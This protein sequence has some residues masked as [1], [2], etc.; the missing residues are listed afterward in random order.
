M[1][2]TRAPIRPDTT[3]AIAAAPASARPSASTRH[4]GDRLELVP[5][6]RERKRHAHDPD[7]RMADRHGHVEHVDVQRIAVAARSAD[8]RRARGQHLGPLR[9]VLHRRDALDASPTNRRRR[10]RRAQSASR[11][12]R[13]AAPSDRPHRRGPRPARASDEDGAREQFRGEAGF[14]DERLLDPLVGL[15]AHRLREQQPGDGERDDRRR[16]RRQEERGAKAAGAIG[17]GRLVR[18]SMHPRSPR[19]A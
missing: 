11:A 9:M 10:G 7:A 16:E 8:A 13:A 3:H 14:G 1:V 5:D 6:A 19:R 4:A 18:A 2:R 15:T 12:R 17:S